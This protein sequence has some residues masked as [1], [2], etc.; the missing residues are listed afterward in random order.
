MT[1]SLGIFKETRRVAMLPG[2]FAMIAMPVLSCLTG[3]DWEHTKEC[4]WYLM[5]EPS[6]IDKTDEGF[7]PVCARNLT[8]NKEKCRMQATEEIARK[9]YGQKFRLVD[10]VV[11][12]EGK[13]PRTVISLKSCE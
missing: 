5:P 2:F 8:I 10:L 9:Y 1:N 12:L 6:L 4:E 11:D 3:C 7:I 13:F